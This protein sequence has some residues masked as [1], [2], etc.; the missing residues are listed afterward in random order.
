MTPDDWDDWALE[1]VPDSFW[2]ARV[3]LR[4]A[5]ANLINE[6][7]KALMDTWIYRKLF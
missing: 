3:R 1:N 6:F 7:K 2:A 4:R 5:W